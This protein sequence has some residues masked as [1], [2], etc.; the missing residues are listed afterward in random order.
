VTRRR[1]VALAAVLLGLAGLGAGVAAA[2]TVAD[3]DLADVLA[4]TARVTLPAATVRAGG[5]GTVVLDIRLPRGYKL[6]PGS[7][8]IYRV[9]RLDGAG[10]A[11]PAA[12]RERIIETPRLPVRIPLAVGPDAG[13][14]HLTLSMTLYYCRDEVQAVCLVQPAVF[15]QPLRVTTDAPGR[16]VR[17]RYDAPV[18]PR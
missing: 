14:G 15:D 3:A 4:H 11:V 17:L 7:P 9:R 10:L 2:D 8:L 13:A 1:E 12:A 18:G 16:E 5:E 6:N